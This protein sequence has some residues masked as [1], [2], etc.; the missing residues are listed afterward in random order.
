[1][2]IQFLKKR[3]NNFDPVKMMFGDEVKEISRME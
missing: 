2:G 3:S 1:M